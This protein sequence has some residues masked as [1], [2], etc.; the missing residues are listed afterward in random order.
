M[1]RFL[2]IWIW[3][4]G[5]A[6]SSCHCV[7]KAVDEPKQVAI[8]AVAEAKA[9][10][11]QKKPARKRRPIYRQTPKAENVEEL[12]RCA[13]K[14]D[15]T[16]QNRLGVIYLKGEKV[17]KNVDKAIEWWTKAAENGSA[18]AQYKL[19]VCYQFGFGVRRNVNRARYWY[20]KAAPRHAPAKAA[21]ASLEE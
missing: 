14:G 4:I 6:V 20:A 19:G 2:V 13:E 21:L 11:V 5:L 10:S 8:N 7:K 16:A 15:T 3:A 9:D 18:V 17:E 12:I 1:M